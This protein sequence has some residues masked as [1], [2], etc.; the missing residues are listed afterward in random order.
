MA[1][2]LGGREGLLD[3]EPRSGRGDRRAPLVP[4]RDAPVPVRDAAHGARPQLHDGRRPHAPPAAERLARAAP[5]GLRLLRPARRERRHPR[6]RPPA[7]DHGHVHRDHPAPD[8]AARLGDRLGPRGVGARD[9]LLPLDAVAV[10]PFLRARPRVPE[11]G[12]GELVPERPDGGRER[13]RDRRALRALRRG[14]RGPQPRAV[15]LQDHRL[16]RRAARVRP[17]SWSR[18]ARADEDDPAQLDRPLRG[19][20]ASLPRRRARRRRP[21]LHDA[22]RHGIRRD[23]L[24]ARARAPARRADRERRGPGV[25]KAHGRE[26]R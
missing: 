5:D 19:S 9:R 24:R 4:A 20:R 26:A 1:A 23:V 22:S 10:P 25:R 7:R 15:V 13:V 2:R 21:R 8:E 3:A 16:R 18:L 12:A 14:G 11:G 17:A 6:R